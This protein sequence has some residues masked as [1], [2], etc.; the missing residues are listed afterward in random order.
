MRISDPVRARAYFEAP[1][2]HLLTRAANPLA[3]T[4]REEQAARQFAAAKDPSQ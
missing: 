2:R 3:E 4:E 1:A